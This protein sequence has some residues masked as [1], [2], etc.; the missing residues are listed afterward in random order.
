MGSCYTFE[1][2]PSFGA[3]ETTIASFS[4]IVLQQL[5]SMLELYLMIIYKQILDELFDHCIMW[6]W[7]KTSNW[8]R[9]SF[10]WFSQTKLFSSWSEFICVIF[11]LFY[12]LNKQFYMTFI[13]SNCISSFLLYFWTVSIYHMD[14]FISWGFKKKS[15]NKPV[16]Q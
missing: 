3:S 4:S 13:N 16:L 14:S 8:E 2:I 11:Y 7:N 9:T 6:I 10:G 5:S 12:K 1:I 15:I